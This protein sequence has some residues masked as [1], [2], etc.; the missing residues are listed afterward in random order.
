MIYRRRATALHAARPAAVLG[1]SLALVIAVIVCPQPYALLVLA[2]LIPAV[3][4]AAQVASPVLKATAIA[5]PLS[6]LWVL[7]TGL[8]LRD[9]LTVVWRLGDWPLLGS[10][11]IT[12]EAIVQGCVLALR[13]LVVLQIGMLASAVADPDRLLHSMQRVT[14]RAG[15]TGALALRL[16]PALAADGRRYADGLRCRADDA[17]L[18]ARGRGLVLSATVGRAIDRADQVASILELRGLRDSSRMR[19]L[20]EPWS[21]HDVALIVSAFFVLVGAIAARAAGLFDVQFFPSI[22]LSPALPAIAWAVATVAVATLP[23]AARKGIQR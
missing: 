7:I 8:L 21:R 15:M 4:A 5:V 16:A 2:A 19:R 12:L 3:A 14:P 10:V 20:P 9:G 6:L 11:D 18:D 17:H 22:E 1:W 23:L 13:G